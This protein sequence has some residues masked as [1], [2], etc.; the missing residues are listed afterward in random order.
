MVLY[1]VD[2]SI[3]IPNRN[4]LPRRFFLQAKNGKIEQLLTISSSVSFETTGCGLRYKFS[5]K[6]GPVV[7]PLLDLLMV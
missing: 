1:F 6:T 5:Q 7:N 3:S 4:P 2:S